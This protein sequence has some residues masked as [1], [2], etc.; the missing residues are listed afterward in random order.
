[1]IER[2]RVTFQLKAKSIE[3]RAD[4]AVSFAGYGSVFGTVDSYND[5]ITPGAFAASLTAWDAK[6]KLPAMLLQHGGG[7]FGGTAEDLIPCG[8]WSEMR[9]DDHGLYCA[10]YLFADNT[11]RFRKIEAALRAE[12]SA[13]DGLSIGFSI[14]KGGSVIDP[15]SELRTINAINLFEVS[16]VT[17][18]ANDPARLTDIRN[19]E[20]ISERELERVLRREFGF[21]RS[22]AK[23][24][25]AKG[26]RAAMREAEPE[27]TP[28]ADDF[29]ELL[30][31][32]NSGTEAMS[33]T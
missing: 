21:S 12:P 29:R 16:L 9:E 18:P 13:L 25:I 30:E 24:F 23:T 7:M 28:G 11:D 5:T 8:N 20:P 10:G 32:V 4:G 27:E 26:Y 22:R 14:P 19:T 3:K 6:G 15:D 33:N 31:A 2:K 17:F 1:M